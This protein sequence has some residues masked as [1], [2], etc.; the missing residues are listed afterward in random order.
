MQPIDFKGGGVDVL[1]RS[2]WKFAIARLRDQPSPL[3]K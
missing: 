2:I 3:F 1:R